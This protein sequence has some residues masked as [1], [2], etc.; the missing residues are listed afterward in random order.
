LRARSLRARSLRSRSLRSRSLRSGRVRNRLRGRPG[1][2][3]RGS[4]LSRARPGAGAPASRFALPSRGGR[5]TCAEQERRAARRADAGEPLRYPR[6]SSSDA[7]E[8]RRSG[9]KACAWR[10]R[11]YLSASVK[12]G[13]AAD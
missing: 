6:D 8:N 3:R 10:R 5:R 1:R 13:A 9:Y 11:P 7:V 4:R 2:T 12:R